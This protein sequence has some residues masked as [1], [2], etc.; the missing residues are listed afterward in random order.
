MKICK[1]RRGFI[2][3]LVKIQKKVERQFGVLQAWYYI[4]QNPCRHRKILVTLC[5]FTLFAQY[6]NWW[7]IWLQPI[8]TIW[9]VLKQLKCEEK[10][11]VWC[12]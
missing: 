5:M 2:L 8:A 11:I 10:L 12:I 3:Q 9:G 6:D 7:W 1:M 4:L